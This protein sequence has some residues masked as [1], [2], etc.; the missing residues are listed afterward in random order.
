M[1]ACNAGRNGNGNRGGEE[2][3]GG[4]PGT[5]R[6]IQRIDSL[7][8]ADG[9]DCVDGTGAEF[10]F[11]FNLIDGDDRLISPGSNVNARSLALNDSFTTEG[12]SFD[13]ITIAPSPDVYCSSDADCDELAGPFSCREMNPDVSDSLSVCA[14]DATVDVIQDSLG[15]VPEGSVSR[16]KSVVVA[17]ANGSSVLG[18]NEDTGEASD[19]FSTD[20]ENLRIQAVL[21][22]AAGLEELYPPEDSTACLTWFTGQGSPSLTFIPSQD[23]C[24]QPL[25]SVSSD[26]QRSALQQITLTGEGIRQGQRANWAALRVSIE[27][28]AE[29]TSA[30]FDRHVLLFTDGPD[31]GSVSEARQTPEF[32]SELAELYGIRLHIVQLDNPWNG[33]EHGPIEGLRQVACSSEGTYLYARTPE[34]VVRHFRNLLHSLA[35]RYV[36]RF[37]VPELEQLPD[38]DYR[39]AARVDFVVNGVERQVRLVGDNS[40]L[41]GTDADSRLVVSTR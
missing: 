23:E 8:V 29:R 35:A 39:L 36:F 7:G 15:F 14:M 41:L 38:G 25:T 17:L 6:E 30:A 24:L 3:G 9:A 16:E 1:I 2:P 40:D 5:E 11:L 19:R 28:L 37:R 20:P 10:E 32:V 33:F 18:L 26:L 21:E 31:T 22:F 12:I 34:G 27:H 4:T 13:E